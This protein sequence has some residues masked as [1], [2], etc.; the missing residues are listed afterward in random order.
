[1]INGRKKILKKEITTLWK[2]REKV[3]KRGK[4]EDKLKKIEEMTLQQTNV[5][6]SFIENTRFFVIEKL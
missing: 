3:K 2:Y 1:M 4:K 5:W 6:K